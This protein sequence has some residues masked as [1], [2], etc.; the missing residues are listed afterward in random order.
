MKKPRTRIK[1]II[2]AT[3]LAIFTICIFEI[4]SVFSAGDPPF[5][6]QRDVM[7][8]DVFSVGESISPEIDE[9]QIKI[10]LDKPK[11]QTQEERKEVISSV[12]VEDAE[13]STEVV[14]EIDNENISNIIDE[15]VTE[16]TTETE[17]P[18]DYESIDVA[19]EENSTDE[20]PPI[21]KNAIKSEDNNEISEEVN[22]ENIPQD[23][24]TEEES[25]P[26]TELFVPQGPYYSID[27]SIY[28]PEEIEAL[29]II[30]AKINEA[31]N[32]DKSEELIYTDFDMSR[33]NYWKVA[34]YFYV[35][36]G[37]KRAANE[38]FDRVT[39]AT[40]FEDGTV[41]YKHMIRL[42]YDDIRTFEKDLE[43]VKDKVDEILSS[44]K[45]GSDEYILRQITEYLRQNIVY[46]YDKY[47]ISHALIEG[48]SVC[49]G[50]A[51]A[52]NMLANR[53][54][55]KSDM[56]IGEVPGRGMHAW[57]RVTM[58]DGS[59]YFYD[60]TYYDSNN[61]NEK[62]IHSPTPLHTTNFKINDY[63]DCWSGK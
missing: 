19:L 31:K 24:I 30:L 23:K 14:V 25:L 11:T 21:D 59:Q 38:T 12:I 7:Q 50:Y 27:F 1:K 22:N 37:Q 39:H 41:N 48:K 16:E 32:T 26:V 13:P 45:A 53:A 60:A 34:S 10:K 47:D 35:Y 6:K 4:P 52:F 62:Y 55:I 49:N 36:Y 57:N 3:I 9:N 2:T 54:G 18:I 51:L 29:N 44:F 17:T 40:Y 46:T 20:I 5:K 56:C 61:P 42:R 63:S 33:E 58:S 8:V 43:I 28:A 15:I